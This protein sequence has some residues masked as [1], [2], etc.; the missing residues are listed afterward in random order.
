VIGEP[1]WLAP[2]QR[3]KAF[4][5]RLIVFGVAEIAAAVLVAA[6]LGSLGSALLP[7]S[8]RSEGLPGYLLLALVIMALGVALRELSGRPRAV[9]ELGWQ[10]P[11]HW[12]KRFWTG[13]GAFG[14]V[15]GMGFLTR[16]VSLL[17]HLYLLGAFLSMSAI[18]GAAFGAVFGLT[19]FGILAYATVAWRNVPGGGQDELLTA[20]G[21]R[22]QLIGALAAP[23]IALIPPG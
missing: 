3:R 16:Q 13:A 5:I 9:P 6:G 2:R 21:R 18:A 17:F 15:M 14:A 12:L 8:W 1:V 22:M 20:F 19:Y 23:T 4:S 11:R 10:V 7:E